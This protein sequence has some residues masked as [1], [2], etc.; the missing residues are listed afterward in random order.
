MSECGGGFM[1]WNEGQEL[2]PGSTD[3]CGRG[4]GFEGDFAYSLWM[5]VFAV[6]VVVAAKY[7]RRA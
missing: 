7:D 4:K 5:A 2:E 3:S 6:I 1:R